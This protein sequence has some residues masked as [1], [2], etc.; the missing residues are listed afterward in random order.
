MR[1][2]ALA[3]LLIISLAQP[4]DAWGPQAHRTFCEQAVSAVW[5]AAATS[6]LDDQVSYC[7]ELKSAVNESAGQRCLDAYAAGVSV[8][9]ETAPLTLFDDAEDHY[10]WDNCPLTWVRDSN[11]WIC[12]GKGNPA[13]DRAL[14]WF[15]RAKSAQDTCSQVRA[16]CTG[17]FY[18][19]SSYFPL[20]RVKY[21]KGCIGGPL[22]DLVD[23]ELA[24]HRTNWT[25]SD[26]CVFSYMKPMAGTDRLTTQHVTFVLTERD[27]LSVQ[28]NLTRQAEYVRNPALMPPT[29][30]ATT[31]STTQP[32]TTTATLPPQPPTTTAP[33][34][35]TT[36]LPPTTV[37]YTTTTRPPGP[38][39]TAQR[40]TSTTQPTP[41]TTLRAGQPNPEIDASLNEIDGLVSDML[42]SINH[43][44]T[45][46]PQTTAN[47]PLI[48]LVLTVAVI[49]VCLLLMA[50]LFS[51]MRKP[52]AS[53]TRKIIL[54]P[55]IRRK[56]RKGA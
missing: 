5:G 52:S 55:S 30:T 31:T 53:Y 29:T 38:P 18:Y 43:T 36:R 8:E 37:T 20:L 42:D 6:C 39:T 23:E 16:F 40:P 33:P 13:M 35:S 46:K 9:P 15:E 44:K 24:A 10:N 2:Y 26:Q 22:D 56:M 3:I 49:L 4:A 1:P 27:F 32:P 45:Q 7:I 34:A 17:G 25:I 54:P 12:S 41:P 47:G 14:M 51:A 11:E 48:V 21:L 50:Y 28:A 19:A